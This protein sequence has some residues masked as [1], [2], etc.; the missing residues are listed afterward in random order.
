MVSGESFQRMFV[1]L[2]AAAP[3]CLGRLKHDAKHG[4]GR[5]GE[6]SE[7]SEAVRL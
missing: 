2:S 4:Q 7:A 1:E 5:T 6:I 3:D